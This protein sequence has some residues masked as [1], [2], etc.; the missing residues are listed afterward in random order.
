M[1]LKILKIIQMEYR[2]SKIITKGLKAED[3]FKKA[4]KPEED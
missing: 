4:F 2:T 3:N 1:T